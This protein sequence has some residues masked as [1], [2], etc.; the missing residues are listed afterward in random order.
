V[1]GTA[2]RARRQVLGKGRLQFY[3]APNETCPLRGIF[4]LPGEPVVALQQAARFT[5]VHYVN[6]RTGGQAS[7]WVLSERLGGG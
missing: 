2:S 6:P 7:G 4:I 3:S 1:G 5:A